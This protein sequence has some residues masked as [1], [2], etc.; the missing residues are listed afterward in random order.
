MGSTKS[1]VP[2]APKPAAPP[3]KAPVVVK[4]ANAPAARAASAPQVKPAAPGPSAIQAK[5]ATSAA[6]ATPAKAATPAASATPATASG[7]MK[8]EALAIAFLDLARF[9]IA[10]RR[11]KD[12]ELAMLLEDFY[13]RI[14][15]GV[16]PAGGR[17]VKFMGD[18]ALV[19]FPIDRASQA[20]RT[21]LMLK[22]DV[23]ARLAKRHFLSTL[24]VRF[25]ADEVMSG[26]IGPKADRRYDV[27]GQAVNRT[28]VL[29]SG[30]PVTLSADAYA[31]LDAKTQ[32]LFKAK[33]DH[34]VAV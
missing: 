7:E 26:P 18:G 2:P 16:K 6:V 30:E 21:L 32:K 20:A 24:V 9:Q 4:T 34:F 17:V 33:G 1:I 8:R 25:H 28:A 10:S 13:E 14:A 3:M 29:R 19:V 15:D 23:D 5:P 12:V 22:S 27:I 31:K 11:V